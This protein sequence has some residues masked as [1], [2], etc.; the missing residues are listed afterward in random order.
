VTKVGSVTPDLKL[1]D[2]L[3]KHQSVSYTQEMEDFIKILHSYCLEKNYNVV[4]DNIGNLYVTKGKADSY[5]CV[6]AH[7]DTNQEIQESLQ[8]VQIEDILIG[9]NR[10][11]AQQVGAGFDDKLGILIALQC[12]EFFPTLK[13]F[14]PA[15]EEVGY[16]GTSVADMSF[17]DDVNFCIQPD[18]NSFSNDII[19]FTNGI[20][21][22]GKDFI[23][24]LDDLGLLSRY[25][26]KETTGVGTD[27]GELKRKGLKC[28]AVNIS[29]GYYNEHTDY[30]VCSVTRL[31]NALNFIIDIITM[32]G[33]QRFEHIPVQP[34][35]ERNNKFTDYYAPVVETYWYQFN[36]VGKIWEKVTN[37][38]ELLYLEYEHC[39]QC[40]Y[41]LDED[42]DDDY[43]RR[44]GCN[45][46]G[47]HYFLA[48]KYENK[49]Y[50]TNKGGSSVSGLW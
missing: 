5:V 7:T 25:S 14:F 24:A 23:Y 11:T 3:V 46:C 27:I 42:R 34:K 33:H 13:V 38:E 9:W 49:S 37:E 12:L 22:A 2:W 32:V 1:L 48:S 35:L 8:L 10:H 26:Y 28:S 18:R 4:E 31:H 47:T 44:F 43:G 50:K 21:T 29:C 30:E 40:G 41:E 17:F 15:L 39:T 16:K 19:T 6:V 45:N 36:N 20:E